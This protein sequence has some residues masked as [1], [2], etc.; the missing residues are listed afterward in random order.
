MKAS[1]SDTVAGAEK[2]NATLERFFGPGHFRFEVTADDRFRLLRQGEAHPRNLSE[3]ERTAIAFCYFVT[4]LFA[5]GP[6]IKDTIVY[7]DDP[8]SS[9][10]ANHLHF[11]DAFIRNMFYEFKPKIGGVRGAIHECKAKQVFIATH[12]S[13][14]FHLLWMW[15]KGTKKDF[16]RTYMIERTKADGY[17]SSNLI[18]CPEAFHKYRSLYLMA[19]DRMRRFV[20]DPIDGEGTIFSMGNFV[21]KFLEGYTHL[22]YMSEEKTFDHHLVKL[23]PDDI[24]RDSVTRFANSDSHLFSSGGIHR[25][26]D[27]YEA[28]RLVGIVLDAVRAD[29]PSHYDALIAALSPS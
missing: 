1:I 20:K 26:P 19:F 22:K 8:I 24:E 9:L 28:A 25:I 21:R 6:D 15:L 5:D 7:I 2:L 18:D 23:I 3:G 10:D 13:E 14:F 4:R 29:D 27:R 16:S 17:A 12:N 11:V